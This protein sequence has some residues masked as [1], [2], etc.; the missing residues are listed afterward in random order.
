MSD[1]V[2]PPCRFNGRLE[3]QHQHTLEAHLLRKLIGGESLTKT[4][5]GIPE[6][7]GGTTGIIILGRLEETYRVL[8]C[9]VLL[10]THTEICAAVLYIGSAIAHGNAGCTD[11]IHRASEP[12]IAILASIKLLETSA[13]EKCMHIV[14]GKAA[15]IRTHGAEGELGAVWQTTGVQLFVD[16][17]FH[18]TVGKTYFQVA[19]MVA[20][21]AV[22]IDGRADFWTSV[23]EYLGHQSPPPPERSKPV[24][25]MVATFESMNF[26]SFSE[27]PHSLQS[28]SSE[29]SPSYRSKAGTNLYLSRVTS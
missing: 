17:G 25:V 20:G 21:N 3:G 1:K 28:S 24:S 10:W 12:F 5:L 29:Y 9:T 6:E 18:I 23:E 27:I 15:A 2:F 19:G 13:F 11:I 8:H 22:G 7:L 26:H 14:V 4:H 16:A